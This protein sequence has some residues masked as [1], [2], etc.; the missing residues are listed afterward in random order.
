VDN[1]PRDDEPL[2][3]IELAIVRALAPVFAAEIR[4]E[5]EREREARERQSSD[6][7]VAS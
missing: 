1:D 2:N 7:E 4:K 3:P 6:A 5:L